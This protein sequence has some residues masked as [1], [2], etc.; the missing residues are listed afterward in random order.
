[1]TKTP[2]W[3][4]SYAIVLLLGGAVLFVI[5]GWQDGTAPPHHALGQLVWQPT[6]TGEDRLL[7]VGDV[8]LARDVERRIQSAT[9]D[10]PYQ[11]LT[12]LF[13]DATVIG[14][15]EAAI[16]ATHQATPDFST[17]F[18]VPAGLLPA[19]REAGF[20]YWSLANNHSYDF[21]A[22]GYEHTV[23]ELTATG[24]V[25][26]G[27]PTDPA[28]ATT[29]VEQG[30]YTIALVGLNAVGVTP[31]IT[32]WQNAVARA[33]QLS[34]LQIAYVH[35]GTEYE[36][37]HSKTEATLARELVAAGADLIVG[38]H[39]HVVQD[40]GLVA[41]VP[42][43]YSLGNF[44]FDQYFSTEVQDGL[45]LA[46]AVADG[47]W[48]LGFVPVTSRY[49]RIQPQL[50]YYQEAEQWLRQ[51]ANRSDPEFRDIARGSV[52]IPIPALAT[53]P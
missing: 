7:F 29:Y 12:S 14:N 52:T 24:F 2:V 25:P 41:G 43:V 31:D 13:A 23:S 38:H 3:A 44:I 42:V 22:A 50:M 53:T 17:V 30:A 9:P 6:Q 10:Y 51:L 21:G 16:P 28:A 27:H 35:W 1:M 34:D 46:V 19:A 5:A 8:L 11:H 48:Q 39:P 47:A 45:V 32:A 36:L 40:V 49:S 37:T 33:S 26:F 4:A 18:S 20:T 15:F